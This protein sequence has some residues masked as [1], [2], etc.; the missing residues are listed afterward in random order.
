M[1]ILV[2][3]SGSS[4]LKYQLFDMEKEEV[5]AKW[6]VERI[7]IEWSKIKHKTATGI[8][9]DVEGFLENHEIALNKV[10][11]LL[12]DPEVWALKD[13]KEIDAVGHRM[14]HGGE[15]FSKSTLITDEVKKT[16][17]ELTDLAPLHN[18]ANLMGVEAVEKVLP[19]IPNVGVFDTAFH[20]TMKPENFLYALPYKRYEEYKIRRYGFHGTSHRYVSQRISE[21]LGRKDL[22]VI[23]C[24]VGNWAS[25]S[26]IKNGEVV[27]TS[28]GLTPL[29]G[30]IMW[31]RCGNIDPAIIPFMMKKE[32][33]SADQID[34][35][36]NKESWVLGLS[37]KSSDHRDIEDWYNA[38]NE[39]EITIMK[40]YTNAILKYIGAY[41]ALLEWVDA[42]V[43]TA[44]VLEN[45]KLQR[46]LIA[47]KLGW[48]G[49]D[50]DA[51]KN[52]FRGEERCLTKD[53]SKVQLWVVPTD[54]EL[55][56]AK[57]TFDIVN[58][59]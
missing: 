44:W 3:N 31:S 52:D 10:L 11:N 12:I 21:I 16:F 38:G 4:S 47:E 25:I 13:L 30:V 45:S 28:M 2:L 55:M 39:R 41:A 49:V 59:K 20:Q 23:T 34:K 17:K 56:I 27:E 58:W 42:I 48:L 14:V 32:N 37:W 36:M 29:E 57:D 33:L 35:I 7:W 9:H 18:P 54:E 15:S 6:L 8:K 46:Q 50:Y 22:K 51:S 43:F 1:K 19:W 26:A 40:M 24:H 53:N 5:L